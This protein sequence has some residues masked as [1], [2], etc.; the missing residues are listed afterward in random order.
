MSPCWKALLRIL[1]DVGALGQWLLAPPY[2][3]VIAVNS[4]GLEDEP[5]NGSQAVALLADLIGATTTS[6]F[7]SFRISRF[8]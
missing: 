6:A 8:F 5:L 1:E 2:G 7:A 3:P 4:A